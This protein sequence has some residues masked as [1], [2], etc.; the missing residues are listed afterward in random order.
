[1]QTC[2]KLEKSRGVVIFANNTS[3]I[4]YVKIAEINAKLIKQYLGLPTTILSNTAQGSNRRFSTD[5]G[6]FVHWNN[7]GRYQA[8]ELS[9]YDET[10]L[11]DADYLIFDNNL[12]KLFDTD[13][14]Y[15]LFDKNIYINKQNI[16]STMGPYS[17]PFIWATAVM[18]RKTTKS[19]QLFELVSKVQRNYGYY[20]ALYNIREGNFRNDYAFA[21]ADNI[22]NGYIVDTSRHAP[23]SI[24][25]FAGPITEFTVSNTSIVVKDGSRAFVLP[26]QSLHIMSKEFLTSGHLE[27]II[28]S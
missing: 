28:D 19:Q 21:I 6:S 15:L 11:L 13:Q 17:L 14:D 24:T 1:M 5:T 23:W 20:R 10:L 18:F 8:Y 3:Q 22:L 12:L 25:T 9:P 2:E 4:D 7:L 16:D 27:K 26:K